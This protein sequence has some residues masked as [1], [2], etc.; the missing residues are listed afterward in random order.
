MKNLLPFA[1]VGTS[2]PDIKRKIQNSVV[3][4]SSTSKQY[5]E[6]TAQFED[7]KGFEWAL[8][9]LRVILFCLSAVSNRNSKI[10]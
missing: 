10:I 6:S 2:L 9:D 5:D 3:V 8:V 4:D 1:S 7:R